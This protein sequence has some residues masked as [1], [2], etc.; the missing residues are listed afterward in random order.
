[1][2]VAASWKLICHGTGA[3]FCAT[4]KIELKIPVK[5]LFIKYALYKVVNNL[6][7]LIN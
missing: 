1:M 5:I 2:G 7:S 3:S 6:F 4:V